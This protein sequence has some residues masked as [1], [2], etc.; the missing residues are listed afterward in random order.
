MKF[1]RQVLRRTIGERPQ[2]GGQADQDSG[3]H[4]ST[5]VAFFFGLPT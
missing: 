1:D 3:H 5:P 4:P 2:P